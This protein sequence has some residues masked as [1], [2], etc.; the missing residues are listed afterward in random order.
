M[1]NSKVKP[2]C[3]KKHKMS[4]LKV[5]FLT[6]EEIVYEL[7]CRGVQ[8]PENEIMDRLRKLLRKAI[9][10][11][12]E[13][14]V[15][16]L[17]SKLN[18][19][20]ELDMI[21]SKCS[22]IKELIQD[23]NSESRIQDIVRIENKILHSRSRIENLTKFH[24]SEEQKSELKTCLS[25]V[26]EAK[27]KVDSLNVKS[28][29]KET[30]V[31]RV[32]NSNVEEE[33]L[34]DHLNDSVFENPESNNQ[35]TDSNSTPNNSEVQ[36][37]VETNQ[38][39]SKP[40]LNRVENSPFDQSLYNKLPNPLERYLVGL[41]Q[42]NGLNICELLNFIKIMFKI[43]REVKLADP[44]I[45]SLLMLH[46]SEPLLNTLISCKE[47]NQSVV[48]VNKCILETYI[49]FN[50]LENLRRDFINR[51]QRNGE[52]IS[53]YIASIKE[54]CEILR[55]NLSETQIV[56]NI[57]MG[58]NPETRSK[59]VFCGDAKSFTELD[60]LCV[61]F[62]NVEFLDYTRSIQGPVTRG[63]STSTHPRKEVTCFQCG[64]EGHVKKFCFRN[65]TVQNN[66]SFSQKPKNELPGGK[67]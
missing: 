24:L 14:A 33:N 17:Q 31:R 45:V 37:S 47:L 39:S 44:H 66:P 35:S 59:M 22:G 9:R 6:K 49:P 43:K 34:L 60:A 51:P 53:L 16:N 48:E 30:Y 28:D 23:L 38:N 62:T 64:R 5:D 8:F 7:W 20:T 11:R 42:T 58:L 57:K 26:S 54:H 41:T 46:T 50:M 55:S 3:H 21:K 10:D 13:Y 63:Q 32:S 2:I 56:S 25:D 67:S 52:P 1:P 40:K 4:E 19:T 61:Q 36:A 15:K 18:L 27:L 12:V 29:L 65:K